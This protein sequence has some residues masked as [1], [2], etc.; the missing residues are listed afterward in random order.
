MW[1]AARSD[2]LAVRIR[3]ELQPRHP[4]LYP[5][6][7]ERERKGEWSFRRLGDARLH[8]AQRRKDALLVRCSDPVANL[9]DHLR[10]SIT[11]DHCQAVY[12]C[13]RLRIGGPYYRLAIYQ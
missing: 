13:L 5:L 4:H 12:H 3:V 7:R 9:V 10:S 1:V 11:A 6:P 8:P 2:S